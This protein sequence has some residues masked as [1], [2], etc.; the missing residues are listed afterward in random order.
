MGREWATGIREDGGIGMRIGVDR[1]TIQ[2]KR[3]DGTVVASVSRSVSKKSSKKKKRLQY[4]FKEISRQ[5]MAAKTSV[6]AGSIAARA[7]RKTAILLRKRK[8]EEYDEQEVEQAIIHARKM[9]RIAKKRKKHLEE[10]EKAKGVGS[11]LVE[12]DGEEDT[13]IEEEDGVKRENGT[14]QELSQEEMEEALKECQQFMEENLAR[15]EESMEEVEEE[16]L[17]ELAYELLS[18]VQ[19]EMNPEALER[20]KKKHRAD[21]WKEIIE[22]DMK[23]LKAL[24]DKLAKEKQNASSSGVSLQLGGMEMPIQAP[25]QAPVAEGG[26]VDVSV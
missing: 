11:C 26:N 8:N 9:E 7:R 17:K 20:L 1:Q 21:E 2:F 14:E 3:A 25:E 23:Y 24:F 13:D 6:G 18:G 4:N 22:A 12:T 5:I 15:M 19:E 16:G 10:E